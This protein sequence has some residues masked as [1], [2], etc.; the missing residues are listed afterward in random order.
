MALSNYTELKAAIATWM[1]RSNLTNQ[2]V[3]FITMAETRINRVLRV[4]EMISSEVLA[5]TGGDANVSLPTGF[6]QMR[7]LRLESDSSDSVLTV[8]PI[9]SLKDER[10]ESGTPRYYAYSGSSIVLYPTPADDMNIIADCF[11]APTALSNSNLTNDILTYYPE[12]YLQ[13]TLAEGYK[14]IRHQAELAKANALFN[15]AVMEANKSSR[16][17]LRS[18]TAAP[19]LTFKRNIP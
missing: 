12:I 8:R 5:V 9:S 19:T 14:Y 13:G 17:L 2:I 10:S 6:L 18:G 16:K 7:S 4:K 11:I 15:E 1:H 3:D